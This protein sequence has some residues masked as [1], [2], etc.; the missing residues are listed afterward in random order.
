MC[1]LMRILKMNM[2][3]RKEVQHSVMN[4]ASQN[5]YAALVVSKP[6]V[7]EIKG[8]VRTSPMGHQSWTAILPS[9]TQRMVGG[10]KHAVGAQRHEV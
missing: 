1:K 6:Y 10:T 8:K 5:E 9:E 4:D 3:K 2:Q 7:F